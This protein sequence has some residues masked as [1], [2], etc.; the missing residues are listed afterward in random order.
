MQTPQKP[1][2]KSVV[3]V[4]TRVPWRLKPSVPS[5]TT[6]V[7]RRV[8]PDDSVSPVSKRA[9]TPVAQQTFTPTRKRIPQVSSWFPPQR[10]RLIEHFQQRRANRLALERIAASGDNRSVQRVESSAGA[11]A[12]WSRGASRI[13]PALGARR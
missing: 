3:Q 4:P 8:E 13:V 11:I 2:P 6:R 9:V 1:I 10:Q 7:Q 12:A 5:E